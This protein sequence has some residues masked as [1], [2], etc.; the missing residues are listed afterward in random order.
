MQVRKRKTIYKTV[1][2]GCIQL[3][4]ENTKTEGHIQCGRHFT[5]AYIHPHADVLY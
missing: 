3:R 2:F 4:T 1:S 5:D